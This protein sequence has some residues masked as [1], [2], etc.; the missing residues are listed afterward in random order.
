V[1]DEI[2]IYIY[3]LFEIDEIVNVG[4]RDCLVLLFLLATVFLV[5]LG[6]GEKEE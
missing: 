4:V 3:G 6:D 1:P 5:W 2:E